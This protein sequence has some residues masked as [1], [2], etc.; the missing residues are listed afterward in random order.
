[1]KAMPGRR[2]Y[3]KD[4]RTDQTVRVKEQG[5]GQVLVHPVYRDDGYW[6]SL[7]HLVP[8]ADPHAWGLRQAVLAMGLLALSAV[9][10][11]GAYTDMTDHGFAAWEAACYATAPATVVLWAIGLLTGLLRR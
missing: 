2:A 1:M 11:F 10:G 5:Y 9:T 4:L 8:A 3:V 7:E 6:V